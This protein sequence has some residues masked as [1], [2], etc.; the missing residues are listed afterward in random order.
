MFKLVLVVITAVFFVNPVQAAGD[1]S[2]PYLIT[3]TQVNVPG[4]VKPVSI[5]DAEPH[6]LTVESLEHLP[7]SSTMTSQSFQ[8]SQPNLDSCIAAMK[9]I[10]APANNFGNVG[11]NGVETTRRAY[12]SPAMQ[13]AE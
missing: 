2:I 3:D 8:L 13:G 10:V 5:H 6:K 1:P 4:Y 7:N 12:C 11:S 9:R